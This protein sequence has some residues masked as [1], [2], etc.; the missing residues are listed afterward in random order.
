MPSTIHGSTAAAEPLPRGRHK[1]SRSEVRDS[2]RARLVTAILELVGRQ[3]YEATTVADVVASARVSRNAF[4]AQFTDLQDCF[5]AACDALG[6]DMLDALYE[7]AEA[8]TWIDAVEA[9]LDAYLDA[10]ASIP[11]FAFAYFV[12]FPTAGRRALDQRDRA[13]ADFAAMF[14]ALAARAR[15]E[16]PELAPLR[17]FVPRILVTAITELIA[18]ESRAGRGGSVADLR[19]ELLHLIVLLLADE[20]T[21]DRVDR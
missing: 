21:A 4:Y 10:W 9:G 20:A 16:Q 11:G 17:P 7:R 13:Y 5:I 19:P 12:E 1:L 3:G 2:Q 6:R 15:A 8:P 14:E 18:Q